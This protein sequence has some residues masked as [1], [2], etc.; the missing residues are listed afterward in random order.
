[1]A[2]ARKKTMR[3][4]TSCCAASLTLLS[5]S[6]CLLVHLKWVFTLSSCL[7]LSVPL[8]RKGSHLLRVLM[9]PRR[10]W[11]FLLVVEEGKASN[12]SIVLRLGVMR[13]F[14]LLLMSSWCP[15]YVRE[16][17]HWA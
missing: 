4:K 15:Q 5:S 8:E 7:I 1:M 9:V 3:T 13:T 10:D 6:W 14:L 12:S 2:M 17:P 11:S 16:V